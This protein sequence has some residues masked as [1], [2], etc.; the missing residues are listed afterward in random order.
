MANRTRSDYSDTSRFKKRIEFMAHIVSFSSPSTGA[1]LLVDSTITGINS[2][3]SPYQ[4]LP[5][6]CLSQFYRKYIKLPHLCIRNPSGC[7]C[8]E[9]YFPSSLTNYLLIISGIYIIFTCIRSALSYASIRPE[10]VHG[11]LF[12]SG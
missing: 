9:I 12:F 4:C 2:S 6:G 3:L 10:Q 5:I 7:Y 11:Y 1:R 8:Q